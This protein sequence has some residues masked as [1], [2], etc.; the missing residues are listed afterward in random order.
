MSDCFEMIVAERRSSTPIPLPVGPS[1]TANVS[2]VI[3][4][5]NIGKVILHS[6]EVWYVDIYDRLGYWMY[7]V[8]SFDEVDAKRFIDALYTMIESQ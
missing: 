5:K 8:Y 1:Y 6:S 3:C 7:S 4:Y 2:K